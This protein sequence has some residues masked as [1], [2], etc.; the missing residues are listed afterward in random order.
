M[1]YS[2]TN[3][4]AKDGSG[5]LVYTVFDVQTKSGKRCPDTGCLIGMIILL[6]RPIMIS[7]PPEDQASLTFNTIRLFKRSTACG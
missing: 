5:L 1:K 7:S 3:K 6:Q 4:I 2:Q